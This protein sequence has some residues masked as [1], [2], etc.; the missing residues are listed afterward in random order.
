MTFKWNKV[1]EVEPEVGKD[2]LVWNGSYMFVSSAEFYN[3]E[4]LLHHGAGDDLI[5]TLM[6]AKGYFAEF[7]QKHYFD[8]ENIYW[9]ELPT[10]P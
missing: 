8:E 2:Y 10:P 5:D 3:R 4:E 1:T 9:A 7:G 6:A